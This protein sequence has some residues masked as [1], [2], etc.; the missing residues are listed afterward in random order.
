MFTQRL[1][2][3]MRKVDYVGSQ[4]VASKLLFAPPA[5]GSEDDLDGDTTSFET[6]PSSMRHRVVTSELSVILS[7]GARGEKV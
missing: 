7:T 4:A 6:E 2:I 5:P 1:L 3:N